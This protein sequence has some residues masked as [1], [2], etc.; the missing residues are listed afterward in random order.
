MARTTLGLRLEGAEPYLS[1][2]VTILAE[3]GCTILAYRAN[4]EG[5]AWTN[6]PDWSIEAPR[7]TTAKRFGVFAHEVGHQLRHRQTSKPRWV[8]ELEAW[9]YAID[10][11]KRFGL[12]DIDGVI[13]LAR[14]RMPYAFGK[15]LR[16]TNRPHEL[17]AEMHTALPLWLAGFSVSKGITAQATLRAQRLSPE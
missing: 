12:P 3:S 7:P 11:H 6:D 13:E 8:R 4:L 5:I 16:R 14:K 17:A 2:A 1:A 10:T 15:A 9:Q